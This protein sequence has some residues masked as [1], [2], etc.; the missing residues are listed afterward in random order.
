MTSDTVPS[1]AWAEAEP[2]KLAS[3]ISA[4]RRRWD[5]FMGQLSEFA[6]CQQCL[7]LQ[8]NRQPAEV[9]VRHDA[10]LLAAQFQDCA[11]L[12]GQHDA[13]H[14]CAERNAC[15]SRGIDAGDILWLAD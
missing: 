9:H 14:A 11:I 6:E 7:L 12:V 10:E 15:A 5:V 4:E 2:A 13:T 1:S 3:A 8:R